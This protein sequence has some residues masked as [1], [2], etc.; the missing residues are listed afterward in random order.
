MFGY[1]KRKS[2]QI[3]IQEANDQHE[4]NDVVYCTQIFLNCIQDIT[5]RRG[6]DFSQWTM[7]DLTQ[8]TSAAIKL[9]EGLK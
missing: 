7:S 6:W 3:T 4:F 5:Q 9:G 2:D 8:F 1:L